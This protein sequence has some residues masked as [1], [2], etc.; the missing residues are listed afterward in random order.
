MTAP[1]SATTALGSSSN[2]KDPTKI[3]YVLDW[4]SVVKKY[5][6]VIKNV[7]VE[8]W[9]FIWLFCQLLKTI[10]KIYSMSEELIL[11][12]YSY[13]IQFVVKGCQWK[14]LYNYIIALSF[15]CILKVLWTL[16]IYAKPMLKF[17]IGGKFWW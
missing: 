6:T 2:F 5:Y 14:F 13:S 4:P 15:N 16:F 11:E 3:E 1:D 8:Q 17:K 12:Y 7:P 10:L 9:D